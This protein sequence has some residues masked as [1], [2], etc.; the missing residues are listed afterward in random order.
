[1]PPSWKTVL[2]GS[3]Q[4]LDSEDFIS[5]IFKF[6]LG[7]GDF[8]LFFFFFSPVVF[9]LFENT[10]EVFVCLLLFVCLIFKN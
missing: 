5:K 4:R 1:M 9:F 10:K 3:G 8:Q 2:P 7:N 6:L